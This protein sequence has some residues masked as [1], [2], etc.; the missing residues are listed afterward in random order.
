LAKQLEEDLKRRS[1]AQ[2]RFLEEV[3]VQEQQRRDKSQHYKKGAWMLCDHFADT[4]EAG[5]TAAQRN[6]DLT[7]EKAAYEVADLQ[8]Q[9]HQTQVSMEVAVKDHLAGSAAELFAAREHCAK[10]RDDM[11]RET[12]EYAQ[13]IRELEEH[14]K[15]HCRGIEAEKEE[16]DSGRLD[17]FKSGCQ[18]VKDAEQ[19]FRQRRVA[20]EEELDGID[21]RLREIESETN[22]RAQRIMAQWTQGNAA[23][24]A[25]V[26]CLEDEAEGALRDLQ[27]LSPEQSGG[28]KDA[29][30]K[31]VAESTLPSAGAETLTELERKVVEVQQSTQPSL[32]AAREEHERA[33]AA[34]LRAAAEL[35]SEPARLAG[36]A[37]AACEAAQQAAADEERASEVVA[38]RRQEA[39]KAAARAA[40]RE[41]MRLKAETSEAWA[42]VRKACFQLRLAGLHDFAAGIVGGGFDLPLPGGR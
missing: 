41:E 34:A 27:A 23:A 24:E 3:R 42:R 5:K 38:E 20:C 2:A 10:V 13:K 32:E 7:R 35:H 30:L 22:R 37:D 11:S 12:A 18:A 21:K 15:A 6:A 8:R 19:R 4:A 17:V 40:N 14:Y 28:A 33:A 39:A 1:E 31:N 26:R 16:L 9:A 36:E 25:E 29:T